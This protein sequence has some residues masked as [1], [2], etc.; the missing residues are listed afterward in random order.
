MDSATELKLLHEN[1][2]R[3][4][5]EFALETTQNQ[6][7][8]SIDL[9]NPLASI[10]RV[11]LSDIICSQIVDT[12]KKPQ[13][14]LRIYPTAMYLYDD[15][16][17]MCARMVL[18]KEN[19]EIKE[20]LFENKGNSEERI[21]TF[22][23]D[24]F[25]GALLSNYSQ[26]NAFKDSSNNYEEFEKHFKNQKIDDC[27]GAFINHYNSAESEGKNKNDIGSISY[28]VFIFYNLYDKDAIQVTKVTDYTFIQHFLKKLFVLAI[29]TKRNKQFFNDIRQK[30]LKTSLS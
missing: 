10:L 11:A 9:K 1:E 6:H 14:S 20:V 8:E 25:V 30:S 7:V 15:N 4:Y 3:L 26:T 21:K 12:S 22:R 24:L 23:N 5:E 16:T 2:A 28:R 13:S 27:I 17:R 18:N 19:C 29:S